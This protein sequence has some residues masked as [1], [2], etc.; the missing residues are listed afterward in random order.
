LAAKKVAE[1]NQ[2]L[3]NALSEMWHRDIEKEHPNGAN[4]AAHHPVILLAGTKPT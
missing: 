2:V 3:I 4:D 1:G